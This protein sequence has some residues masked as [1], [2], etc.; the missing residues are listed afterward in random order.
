MVKLPTLA[1]FS[2]FKQR[3]TETSSLRWSSSFIVVASVYAGLILL[4][5]YWGVNE[6]APSDRPMAAIMVDLAPLPVAP[7]IPTRVELPGPLQEEV[8]PPPPEPLPEP[9]LEVEPLPE[10]PVIK[11][12]EVV[13]PAEPEAVEEKVEPEQIEAQEEQAPPASEAP[14]DDVAAAP[15]EGAVSLAPSTAVVTWQSVLLGHLEHHK[16]YPRK[17]RRHKQEA[18]VYVSITINRDGAVLSAHLTHPSSYQALNEETLA[19]IARAEP[20]PPPPLD[21]SGETIEFVVPVEYFLR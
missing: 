14:P 16:R 19:L 20:L 8:P 7:E 12:A 1:W 6:G 18:V 17:S 13:L 4:A 3:L 15:M 9:K 2:A 5:L 10:L 11:E 21:V